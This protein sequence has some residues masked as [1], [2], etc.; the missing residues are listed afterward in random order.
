M[1]LD[2]AWLPRGRGLAEPDFEVRHRLITVILA[3]HL[4]AIVIYAMATHHSFDVGLLHASTVAVLLVGALVPGARLRRSLAASVGLLVCSAV[5]VHQSGGLIEMHFHYFV[6]VAVI[7]LYQEWLVYATAILFVLVEHGVLGQID[8][9]YVFDHGGNPWVLA[10]VH[11][12]FVCAMAAAQLGFW[13][14]QER[15]R[16]NEEHYRRQL[17]DGQES[18]VARLEDAAQLRSDLVGTVTHEFRTPLTGISGA[19]LTLRRRRHRLDELKI[20]ELLDAALLH[21]DRLR[22]LLENMLTAA[23]ATAVDPTELTDVVATTCEIVDMLPPRQ[24]DRLALDLPDV[25]LAH[26]GREALHQVLANLVDNALTHSLPGTVVSLS[27]VR[28]GGD[29]VIRVRNSGAE[30]A[31]ERI[32]HLLEPF[33]QVDGSITRA[34][35]GAGMGL[36]V[37]RRLIEVHGGQLS[38]HATDGT[39]TAEVNVRA[40]VLPDAVEQLSP[41]L[42]AQRG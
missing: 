32:A 12:G 29:A 31:P 9:Q 19:L 42:P 36:Y 13:H 34:R 21:A 8:R 18:L 39:V 40:S 10:G 2:L 4:P 35:E 38:L 20:D 41:A 11:A 30:I 7:A 25:L 26:I 28:V 27:C 33:T 5:L 14:Y 37:V 17:F 1:S 23:E 24:R 3:L 15:A 16:E 22:R 6:A